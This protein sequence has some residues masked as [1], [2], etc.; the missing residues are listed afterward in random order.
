M[1]KNDEKAREHVVPRPMPFPEPH[2]PNTH[3][4]ILWLFAV[5]VLAGAIYV[6]WNIVEWWEAFL[7]TYLS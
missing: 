6:A 1:T 3:R 5:A 4:W 2:K 7:D